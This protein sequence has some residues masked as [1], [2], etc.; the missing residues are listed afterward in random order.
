MDYVHSFTVT[1]RAKM[2]GFRKSSSYEHSYADFAMNGPE[3][4]DETGLK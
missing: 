3:S 2:W 4:R 1:E